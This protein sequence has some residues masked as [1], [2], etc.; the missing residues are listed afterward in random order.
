MNYEPNTTEWKIG[1]FV[2]HDADSKVEF[3]LMKVVKIIPAEKIIPKLDEPLYLTEYVYP[4]L[5]E[6]GIYENDKKFLHDPAKFNIKIPIGE[7]K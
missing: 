1:D 5:A 7:S 3:M 6:N 2:I 4:N